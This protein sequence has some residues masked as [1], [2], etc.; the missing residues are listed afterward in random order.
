MQIATKK[1]SQANLV[2]TRLSGIQDQIGFVVKAKQAYKTQ[3]AKLSGLD[4][5]VYSA[6]YITKQKEAAKQ[7]YNAARAQAYESLT[8]R[9]TELESAISERHAALDLN[10]P[11]WQSALS[12]LQAG[13][14][15]AD[16]IRQ[17][18]ASFVYDQP[19][20]RA[21]QQVYKKLEVY[22]GGVDKMI[23]EIPSSFDK[24]RRAAEDTFTGQSGINYFASHVGKI[25]SLEGFEF[26]SSPD[27][28][29]FMEAAFRGAGLTVEG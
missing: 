20:L 11:A 6:D 17:I 14:K 25:A 3:L 27:P 28:D 5:E 13:V 2:K 23:Y 15:D 19:A 7:A 21:L 29:G 10:N 12:L 1:E 4:A 24:V 22:D 16:T 18:N 9:L 8:S 26:D